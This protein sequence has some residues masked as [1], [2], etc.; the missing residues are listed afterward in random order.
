MPQQAL[1]TILLTQKDLEWASC[2]VILH[3]TDRNHCPASII[4]AGNRPEGTLLH[5]MS[6]P[7]LV[8]ILLRAVKLGLEVHILEE[9]LGNSLPPLQWPEPGHLH[10]LDKVVDFV[11]T[12]V[13]QQPPRDMAND[14][15]LGAAEIIHKDGNNLKG[16]LGH[17]VLGVLVRHRF[18]QGVGDE[19]LT[20]LCDVVHHLLPQVYS[21]SRRIPEQI[22][23]RAVHTHRGQAREQEL[24]QLVHCLGITVWALEERAFTSLRSRIRNRELHG[25]L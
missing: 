9:N 5:M 15:P 17:L 19:G 7:L 2:I 4:W 23:G 14:V 3:T 25:G 18:D 10:L 8:F 20:P 21:D 16:V 24:C 22:T 6:E 11:V 12:V 13:A 1:V